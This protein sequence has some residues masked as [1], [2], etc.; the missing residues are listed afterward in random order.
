MRI[1]H[2][3]GDISHPPQSNF[4]SSHPP[5]SQPPPGIAL[6]TRRIDKVEEVCTVA[7]KAGKSD[8]LGYTFN[9][10]QSARNIRPRYIR[11]HILCVYD[12]LKYFLRFIHII[13]YWYLLKSVFSE[14]RLEVIS[15]LVNQYGTLAQPD[16]SNVCFGLQYLNRPADVAKT[17]DNLLRG[18]W[19]EEEGAS[20]VWSNSA[21]V[22]MCFFSNKC[23]SCS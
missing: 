14:F 10:C 13:N 17:L 1:R 3:Y 12:P 21:C 8:L 9:L 6:D 11:K 18:K 23:C 2:R 5:L 19:C 22:R 16:Y 7:I 4:V 20:V 15:V